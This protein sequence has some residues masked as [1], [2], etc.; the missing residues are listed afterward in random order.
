MDAE[1]LMNSTSDLKLY[2]PDPS[3]FIDPTPRPA[4]TPNEWF[5]QRYPDQFQKFGSPFLELNQRVD[6]FTD[7]TLPLTLNLDFFAGVLGGQKSYGHHVVYLESEMQWFFKDSDGIFKPTSP[8]KLANLYRALLMKCCQEMPPN[9]HKLNLFHEFRS[10]KVAK[11]VV[12]RAKSILA[13]DSSFFSA[14]SPHQRIRGPELHER[15]IMNLVETMLERSDGACLTVTQAYQIFCGLSERRGLGM[16]K[17]SVFKE[18]MRDCVRDRF[19][20]ALRHD[21]PDHENRHQQAW[22][23]LKLIGDGVGVA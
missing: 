9:T 7:Q 2:R 22:K 18:L 1:T 12:Q 6:Q 11:A 20:L 23:G 10:D 14:Q 21:V 17:R 19:D 5:G 4:K 3:N 15:L 8:E 16:L 13:A